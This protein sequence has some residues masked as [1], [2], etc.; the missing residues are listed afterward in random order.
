MIYQ[1]LLIDDV[2]KIVQIVFYI[3]G[4]IVAILTYLSAKKGLLNTVNTEYQKRVMD[5]LKEL[6]DELASEFI[7]ESPNFWIT[8]HNIHERV[9]VINKEFLKNKK[10]ILEQGI[11][12]VGIPWGNDQLR[13]Y[14][15]VQTVKTDPFLPRNI[16]NMI[17]EALEKRASIIGEVYFNVLRDYADNLAKGIGTSSKDL[18]TNKMQVHNNIVK[19]LR[20]QG[21]GIDDIESE[22]DKIRLAIQSYFESFDPL[23]KR[24]FKR[25]R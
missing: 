16:R 23:K 1:N 17:V 2:L 20:E 12:P 13:L 11:F 4:S 15:L 3:I 7:P 25:Y 5:R 8:S 10:S 14:K 19:K 24:K 18:E 22:I 9:D 21:V 6:S